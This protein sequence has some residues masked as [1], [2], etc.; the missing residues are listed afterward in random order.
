MPNKA[1][2]VTD[3][4]NKNHAVFN[5]TAIKALVLGRLQ[6]L[7]LDCSHLL[8]LRAPEYSPFEPCSLPH[9]PDRAPFQNN[10]RDQSQTFG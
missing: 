7:V 4:Q 6:P 10:S 3:Y 8:D 2:L 9:Q 1:S 5:A